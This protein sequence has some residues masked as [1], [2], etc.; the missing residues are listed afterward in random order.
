MTNISISM[1]R[2]VESVP[3]SLCRRFSRSMSGRPIQRSLVGSY[4]E[5]LL[6]GRLSCG[7]A[8]QSLL[9]DLN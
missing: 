4:K 7:T 9:E 5:S 8:N 1:E 6:T 2:G 3:S